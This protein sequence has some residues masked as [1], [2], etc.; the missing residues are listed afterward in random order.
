MKETHAPSGYGLSD[1]AYR[2]RVF[3]DAGEAGG[4]PGNHIQVGL[5]DGGDMRAPE[6]ENQLTVADKP[7]PSLPDTSVPGTGG[8]FAT[9]ACL[10]ASGLFAL[11]ACHLHDARRSRLRR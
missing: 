6:H 9:G 10:I 2:I 3:S 7:I 5:E 8:M 11:L 1:S 4:A